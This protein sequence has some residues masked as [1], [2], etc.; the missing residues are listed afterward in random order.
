MVNIITIDGPAS[1]GKGTVAKLVATKLGF[2]Y[3]DSG[4]I[5]R[6]L[7]FLVLQHN[8]EP[9]DTTAILN[10]IATNMRLEFVDFKVILNGEDVTQAIRA[11]K[12]GNFASQLSKNPDIRNSLL[13]FQR[14]FA[15]SANINDNNY[16]KECITGL[17]TD[18]RDMGSVVF[19]D[20]VLKVFLTAS[21]EARANRRLKQ[22]QETDKSAI[23]A[24]I[25]RDIINR[26]RQDSLRSVA[27]LGYDATYRFL[28]N[29]NLTIEDTVSQIVEWYYASV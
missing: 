13:D 2:N 21:V 6:A 17:V 12:I 27:P 23:I 10:L 14:S 9:S 1:S 4:S 15:N 5:Y 19:R 24:P 29:T 18:G 3:L 11:E 25:L 28:D 26:D 20:A 7:A 16:V 8:I 22:L